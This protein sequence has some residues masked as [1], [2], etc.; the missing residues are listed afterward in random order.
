[1]LS[2]ADP[3]HLL[4]ELMTVVFQHQI[5]I[6][7][8]I[9]EKMLPLVANY[10]C[11]MHVTLSFPSF[12]LFQKLTFDGCCVDLMKLNKGLSILL[13]SSCPLECSNVLDTGF[14]AI[15]VVLQW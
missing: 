12:N 3:C 10:W 2:G 14:C 4:D 11:H 7:A 15:C 1:M 9:E 8:L 6:V 5:L 13:L